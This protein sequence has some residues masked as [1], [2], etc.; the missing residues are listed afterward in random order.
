MGGNISRAYHLFGPDLQDYVKKYGL[1]MEVAISELKE[2]AA[3]IGSAT[4]VDEN[5]Y[6]KVLPLLSKM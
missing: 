6:N 2:T 5:Y 1:E 3:F 4:L